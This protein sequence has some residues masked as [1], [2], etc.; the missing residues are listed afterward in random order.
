MTVIGLEQISSFVKK[1]RECAQELAELV[2][3]LEAADLPT[4]EA[5][6]QR[7]PSAKILDGRTVV[8]K[9]RGNRYRLSA[10]IAYNTG[11]IIIL[12]VETHADY[13]RRELR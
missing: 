12:G 11:T 5:L 9:V 8:F 2:R 10:K 4:P 13:D 1:H 7:Y 3:D 6:R